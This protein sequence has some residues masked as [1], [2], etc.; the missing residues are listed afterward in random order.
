VAFEWALKTPVTKTFKV[1]RKKSVPGV[2]RGTGETPVIGIVEIQEEIEVDLPA[3]TARLTSASNE[4]GHHRLAVRFV[5]GRYDDEGVFSV[6]TVD[7]GIVFS[8]PTYLSHGFHTKLIAI[9]EE[10][11][12]PK[13]A[14]AFRWDGELKERADWAV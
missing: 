13:I 9:E 10:E 1:K 3:T 7:N 4:P 5:Y 8:G 11:L 14:A 12:L 2:V 6:A